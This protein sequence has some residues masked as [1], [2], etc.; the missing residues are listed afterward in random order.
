MVVRAVEQGDVGRAG[1][2]LLHVHP[3]GVRDAGPDLFQVG[4]LVEVF[5]PGGQ[6]VPVRLRRRGDQPQ[7]HRQVRLF[8]QLL[9]KRD[10]LLRPAGVLQLVNQPVAA[11]VHAVELPLA[12]QV[13]IP[14]L[15]PHP[16]VPQGKLV[17]QVLLQAGGIAAVPQGGPGESGQLAQVPVLHGR[18]GPVR[19]KDV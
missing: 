1:H 9:Q 5:R 17:L 14:V 7:V 4:R 12:Q 2:P 8:R 16:A 15:Q 6:L 19:Q 11:E 10:I 18:E 13:L 3:D